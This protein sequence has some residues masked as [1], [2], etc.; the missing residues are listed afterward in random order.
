M[1]PGA[2]ALRHTLNHM[3]F[4]I[5]LEELATYKPTP[6]FPRTHRYKLIKLFL[7][8]AGKEVRDCHFYSDF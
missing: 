5:K 1:T 8:Q 2:V 7:L 3:R 6:S 4:V